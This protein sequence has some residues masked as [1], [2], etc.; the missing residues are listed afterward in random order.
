MDLTTTSDDGFL[1]ISS[2][3]WYVRDLG[4]SVLALK[5]QQ[6]VDLQA[7]FDAFAFLEFRS[8]LA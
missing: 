3:I 4:S 7:D 5:H 6:Y 8:G 2:N 1:P